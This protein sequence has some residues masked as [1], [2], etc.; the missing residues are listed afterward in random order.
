MNDARH[1]PTADFGSPC[2]G[3]H[4]RTGRAPGLAVRC[5]PQA[6]MLGFLLLPMRGDAAS[7]P[8]E[9]ALDCRRAT[10]SRLT[11]RGSGGAGETMR[12]RWS[13]FESTQP[14]NFGD[15]AA[16]TG[17]AL[18]GY[19]GSHSALAF[20]VSIPAGSSAWQSRPW[21]YRYQDRAGTVS[22]IRSVIMKTGASGRTR[23][24]VRG[25]G[26][27]LPPLPLDPSLPLR[28]QFVGDETGTCWEDAYDGA[29]VRLSEPHH[30]FLKAGPEDPSA[31]FPV[32]RAATPLQALTA[33][34]AGV[35]AFVGAPAVA[36]PMP[37]L[38]VPPHP[39]LDNDGDARIHH[40]AYN[41]AVYNRSGPLG[42]NPTIT[43]A[44]LVDPGDITKVCAMIAFNHD[45]YGIGACIHVFTAP[46]LG[47]TTRLMMIDPLTLDIHADVALAPRPLVQGGAGGAYFSVRQDGKI[48]IG[49]GNNHVEIWALEV[50]GGK[51]QFVRFSSFDVSGSVPPNGLLQDTV[52]DW[53]GRLWFIATT[54]EVG[55]VDP[56]SRRVEVFA[57]GEALQNS[58]AVDASGVYVTTSASTQKFSVAVD[59]SIVQ[60]WRT[61]YDNSGPGILQPGSGTT[62]TLFGTQDDLIGICDT[63]TPQINLVVL[64][65][66]TGALICQTPLFRPNESGTE[67]TLLTVGDDAVVVNNAGFPGVFGAQRLVYPGMERHRVRADRSGC[68]PVWVN[69]AAIANSAQLSTTT[70]LIY[71][72]APDPNVATL[73]AYYLTANDWVTG[74]EV[75]RVYAGNDLPFNPVLGQPHLGRSGAAYVG[76]LHG[77]VRVADTP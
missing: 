24:V 69:H 7:C 6:L 60:H 4:R 48:V 25:R 46:S 3:G 67:N 76:T 13:D 37:P 26:R 15:P 14:A 72:W 49:P 31:P 50:N 18:C 17:Y 71:G 34:E 44:R 27:G 47:S 21:G 51:P 23:I 77:I 28:L 43:T 73:D 66:T 63:A 30:L 29:D 70:G 36:A 2:D 41:S 12:W 11:A 54:G 55:Y 59:G 64:D 19:A 10:Q 32:L 45:G 61:P 74:A 57:T 56:G 9:P 42:V 33:A 65:R 35:A 16:T 40:D 20:E 68:D 62:P 5:M 1:D 52:V 53:E 38:V 8:T 22:G 58:L 39:T 75:F